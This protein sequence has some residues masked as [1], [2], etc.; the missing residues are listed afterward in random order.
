MKKTIYTLVG[1]LGFILSVSSCSDFLKESSDD[2]LIPTNVTEFQSVLYGEAYPKTFTSDVEWMHLMTDDAEVSPSADATSTQSEGND[3]TNLPS[4]KGPFT[5]A[6]DIEYF[7]PGYNNPYVGRYGNIMACNIVIE[8]G[9]TMTGS[10]TE[11]ADCLAQAHTLRAFSYFC[12]VNWYGLPYNKE[13]ASTDMGVVIRTKSEVVRDQPQRASVAEVYQLINNDLD[14]ALEYF[15]AVPEKNNIY[16]V[17]RKVAL[18]LKTRVA[19]FTQQ[20][21]DVIKYGK[22]FMES[23][24][25]LYDISKLTADEMK[26]PYSFLDANN[27]KEIIFTFGGED[28]GFFGPMKYA[29][30]VKGASF[31]P[32]QTAEGSLLKSY[33]NGDNRMYAF[34]MQNKINELFGTVIEKIDY[35]HIPFKHEATYSSRKAY[36]EAFRVSEVL[37]NMAE[38]YAQLG[39][40]SDKTAAI[41]LLNELRSKRFTSDTYQALTLAD[42]SAENSLLDFARAERRRELCFEETHRWM[43]LRREGMPR[44]EHQYYSSSTA[45]PETYVLEQGD[46]NYTLALPKQELSNNQT[47]QIYERRIISGK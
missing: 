18:L 34:F 35:R 47:I 7:L 26:S 36:S 5:W 12:L 9:N 20:W 30:M 40:E 19:L 13:T 32:S 39:T 33:Q 3:N 14:K 25:T 28:Y 44:I 42:F 22:E 29:G 4:G 45:T 2:L 31:V 37:L 43:D 6:Y 10:K 17:S 1:S 23:G 41:Q 8:A 27:N 21:Q 38:A 16:T 15:Q 46:T 24:Y 11:I